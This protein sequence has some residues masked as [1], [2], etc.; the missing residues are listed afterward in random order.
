MPEL[1][2]A[3]D[4][5]VL[6]VSAALTVLGLPPDK[7]REMMAKCLRLPKPAKAFAKAVR[8]EEN[9]SRHRQIIAN[10]RRH[11]LRSRRYPVLL[12]D[13][14]WRGD[15]AQGKRSPYPRLSIE[16]LCAFRLDDGRLIRDAMADDSLLVLWII[17]K[18]SFSDSSTQN[19]ESLGWVQ[20]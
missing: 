20:A 17:D 4:S 7:Q 19:S 6:K 15:I 16:E 10:A 2:D 11:D 3:V 5:G 1:Q 8:A 13:N 9:E 18:V 14:P 12:A